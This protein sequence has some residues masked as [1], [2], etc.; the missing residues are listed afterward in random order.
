V[1]PAARW[2]WV[3]LPSYDLLAISLI[4]LS[5]LSCAYANSTRL[6]PIHIGFH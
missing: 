6:P 1:P 3:L 4:F 2:Y 5:L